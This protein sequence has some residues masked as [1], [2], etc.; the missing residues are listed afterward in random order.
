MQQTVNSSLDALRWPALL[1]LVAA[2]PAAVACL[3]LTLWDMAVRPG[4]FAGLAAGVA[5]AAWIAHGS[6][7]TTSGWLFVLEHE[8]TH[9]LFAAATI[10]RVTSLSAGAHSGEMR[11]DGPGNWL[12]WLS[13]YF[14]PTFC[15]PVL[16]AMQGSRAEW[17]PVWLVLL[18]MALFGHIRG[19]ARELHL[20]QPDLQRYGRVF[21]VAM[22]WTATPSVACAVLWC[23]PGCRR[24]VDRRW[25]Q[26]LEVASQALD[27]WLLV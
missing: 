17:M 8:V 12:V 10:N 5:V 26:V 23:V 24:L 15:V 25:W 1:L 19:T 6:A 4:E 9:A 21:S 27:R 22:I 11:F 13:P 16:L 18:G 3:L 7:P 14:F 2:A 20:Q